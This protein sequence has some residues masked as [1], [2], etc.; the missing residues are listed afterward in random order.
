MFRI[1]LLIICLLWSVYTRAETMLKAVWETDAIF[2]AP[3]SVLY[4]HTQ[5]VLYVA[6]ISGAPDQ[7]DGNGFIS[8]LSLDGELIERQWISGLNAPKGMAISQ[9]RLYVA[10][11][12]ALVEIDPVAGEIVYRHSVPNAKF[13]NDVAAD[14]NG[15]V[16]VSDTFDNTIYAL[17][18]GSLKVWLRSDAL[19]GPNGLLVDGDRMI[20]A[21]LGTNPPNGEPVPGQLKYVIFGQQHVGNLGDGSPVGFMDGVEADGNGGYFATDWLGG[22]LLRIDQSG[23]AEQLLEL[24]QGTADLEVLLDQDLIIIPLMTQG[25]VVA[26]RLSEI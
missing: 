3:E 20:I 8:K 16:Y 5:E 12:D 21:T 22:R 24:G 11:I 9:G 10:D 14:Q 26:Y 7:R 17:S 1:S 4:D 23:V 19:D 15:N 13:F 25:K 2:E 6:N 18:G